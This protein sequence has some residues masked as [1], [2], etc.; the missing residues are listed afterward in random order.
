MD[1]VKLL[2]TSDVAALFRVSRATVARWAQDGKLLRVPTP[3][4]HL[5]FREDAVLAAMA[6]EAVRPLR[7]AGAA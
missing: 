7:A 4:T 3:G 1:D 6:P 5:R 2:T